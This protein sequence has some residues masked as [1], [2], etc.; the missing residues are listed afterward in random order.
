[1]PAP[2]DTDPVQAPATSASGKRRRLNAGRVG[3]T[4]II[5]VAVIAFCVYAF[6]AIYGLTKAG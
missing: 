5:T 1:M 4:I 3:L 6:I 2:S